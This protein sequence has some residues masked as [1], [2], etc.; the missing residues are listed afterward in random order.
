MGVESTRPADD[1]GGVRAVPI[2]RR[3]DQL[4]RGAF[5]QAQQLDER[6][7]QRRRR[8][9]L[10]DLVVD[11]VATWDSA[12]YIAKQRKIVQDIL[13]LPRNA[14]RRQL[15]EMPTKARR[16]QTSLRLVHAMAFDG[17]SRAE[18]CRRHKLDKAGASRM[19]EHLCEKEPGLWNAIGAISACA[20]MTSWQ[21]R[22]Q[23]RKLRNR[24]RLI[25]GWNI[26]DVADDG[27]LTDYSAGGIRSMYGGRFKP[28]ALLRRA[29]QT[30]DLHKPS[31]WRDLVDGCLDWGALSE[32][33]RDVARY[34]TA[35][36]RYRPI[37]RAVRL[38]TKRRQTM[39]VARALDASA[40]ALV[41]WGRHA[42]PATNS[43]D[44]IRQLAG[45]ANRAERAKIL[46]LDPIGATTFAARLRGRN[47]LNDEPIFLAN[48]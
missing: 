4:L 15:S 31:T 35:P 21:N 5:G 30:L 41:Y 1:R 44:H 3:Q 47:S 37:R 18:Y 7:E 9:L 10:F 33:V 45:D 14:R 27:W 38:K 26:D 36:N 42:W 24:V 20:A 16:H 8:S 19:L 46:G 12:G 28:T 23:Q 32:P 48:P 6:Y 17:L 25:Y 40:K 29:I 43:L 11:V 34:E 22:Q 13:A 2:R 39:D